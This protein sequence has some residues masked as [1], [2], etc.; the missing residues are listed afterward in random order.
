MKTSDFSYHLPPALIAQSPASQRDE[1]RLMVLDPITETRKHCLFKD[2]PQFIQP[3]DCLVLNNTRV[4]PARLLGTKKG[5]E[6]AVE[7]LLLKR[8]DEVRWEV[9]VRPGRRLKA[10]AEVVFIE[11]ELEATVETVL[12]TGNRIVRFHF[13][14]IWEEILGRAGQLPLP[15]Y[16]HE[17]LA[18]STRY[19]TVYAQHDGSAAAPTAG[20]HF[21]EALLDQLRAKGV[22]VAE[23]LLHVGL[24]TFRPVQVE[25]V[26]A[27]H[28]HSEYYEITAEQAARISQVRARGGR[29]IAVGTTSTRVLETVAAQYGQIQ[30]ASGW[31]DIFI[32]P[33]RPFQVV[34]GLI[35]N[36]HLPESTLMML[37]SAFAGRL[38]MLESYEEAVQ[39]AY[40]FFSFGD[41]MFI[42]RRLD[43]ALTFNGR[44]EQHAA[45]L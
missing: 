44:S 23:V 32:Y 40:R 12:E 10:G 34:D 13:Q 43:P 35:T 6:T 37:V 36:F 39:K 22:E 2:L 42:Q 31:T 41:A 1:S 8:L 20:L 19:N 33:G 38:F 16:I 25:T 7:F 26:E 15:P 9:L 45:A 11:N 3:G 5:Q 29:I 28:M 27:H 18:D 30:A 21:T 24:G 14:G 4:I 17:Q